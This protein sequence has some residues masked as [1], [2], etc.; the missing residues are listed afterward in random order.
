MFWIRI[1]W[2]RNKQ[3]INND[4]IQYKTN[5]IIL[6]DT[7]AFSLYHVDTSQQLFPHSLLETSMFTSDGSQGIAVYGEWWCSYVVSPLTKL[8]D[9][10]LELPPPC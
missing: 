9:V 10:S 3:P 1:L 5:L 7:Q 2:L 6:I 8:V 4:N